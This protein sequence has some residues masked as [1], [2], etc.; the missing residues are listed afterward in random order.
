[1]CLHSL[2]SCV[3]LR[4]KTSCKHSEHAEEI[5]RLLFSALERAL[6]WCDGRKARLLDSRR[7][8][9]NL[10]RRSGGWHLCKCLCP[11]P[12]ECKART[13]MD[14]Y[15]ALRDPYLLCNR[16]IPPAVIRYKQE[17]RIYSGTKYTYID[18]IPVATWILHRYTRVLTPSTWRANLYYSLLLI[19]LCK[20]SQGRI[21][22]D[23]Y[24]RACSHDSWEMGAKRSYV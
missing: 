8:P 4:I 16:D 22:M 15:R 23:S 10:S 3:H 1:M 17:Y 14:I 20:E 18:P 9:C 6:Y 11:G 13:E 19:I 24:T 21:I 12:I 2:S 7:G 5:K